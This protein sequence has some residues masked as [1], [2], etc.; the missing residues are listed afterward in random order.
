MATDS[1]ITVISE[2]Q[3]LRSQRALN[4]ETLYGEDFS[5]SEIKQWFADEQ[6]GY[7]NLYFE[8]PPREAGREAE[9]TYAALAEQHGYSWLG[10]RRFE[11][12]LGIGSATGSELVPILNRSERLTV[13]EPSDGFAATHINGKPVTYVKPHASG[14][15]PFADE[16]FDGVTSFE[17]L[18]HLHERSQFLAELRRVLRPGGSLVLSTPNASYT[19]PVNGK[20]SNPFHIFEYTPLELRAELEVTQLIVE[21]LQAGSGVRGRRV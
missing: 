9:Y 21:V 19:K 15:M 17:T 6:D 3:D 7:F 12:T 2:N 14:L 11:N 18:E 16:S 5:A 4:A 1:K 10:P 8:S 20:P 13:L